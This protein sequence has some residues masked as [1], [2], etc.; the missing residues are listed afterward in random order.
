MTPRMCLLPLSLAA[1]AFGHVG[2]DLNLT[3]DRFPFPQ[4]YTVLAGNGGREAGQ[5]KSKALTPSIAQEQIFSA[6]MPTRPPTREAQA[7]SSLR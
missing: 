6:T 2:V 1:L 5:A 7:T 4:D 3:G